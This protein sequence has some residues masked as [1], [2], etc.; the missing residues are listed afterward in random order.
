[1]VDD[2]DPDPDGFP[3]DPPDA[4]DVLVVVVV[5]CVGVLGV[6]GVNLVDAALRPP[7]TEDDS[8][9]LCVGVGE[10]ALAVAVALPD[11]LTEHEVSAVESGGESAM[12]RESVCGTLRGDS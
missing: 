2:A 3:A 4:L 9:E 5:A 12:V 8:V 7:P 1:M 11:M 10:G 6:L